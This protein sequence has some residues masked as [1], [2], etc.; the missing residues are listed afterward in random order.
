MKKYILLLIISL[1]VLTGI[2]FADNYDKPSSWAEKQIKYLFDNGILD[3][4]LNGDFKKNITRKEFAYLGVRLYEL[5]TGNT[6]DPSIGFKDYK[7]RSEFYYDYVL[8]ARSL[9]IVSGYSD[10]TFKPEKNI[11]RSEICKMLADSLRATGEE[12]DNKGY[13]EFYDHIYIPKW[14]VED[15]YA[16]REIGI[17]NGVGR[18]KFMPLKVTTREQALVMFYRAYEEYGNKSLA[19]LSDA[20]DQNNRRA[21]EFSVRT[22]TGKRV[23]LFDYRGKMLILSFVRDF[24]PESKKLMKEFKNIYGKFR[25]VE[26]LVVDI[27]KNDNVDDIKKFLDENKIEYD[28]AIDV[29]NKIASSYNVNNTPMT[30]L[31]D[32]NGY[33]LIDEFGLSEDHPIVKKLELIK[34]GQR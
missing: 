16:V 2:T 23:S 7:R 26:K 21:K 12:F 32:E 19:S 25:N 18:N 20:T 34:G 3:E 6:A 5:I 30:F 22:I 31:I 8:K 11:K 27:R 9:N 15:V 29:K 14:A 13:K 1:V 4:R 33:V 17:I 28:V 10:G 24:Q